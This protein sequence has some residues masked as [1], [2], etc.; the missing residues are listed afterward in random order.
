MSTQGCIKKKKK[1]YRDGILSMDWEFKILKIL[2]RTTKNK[3]GKKSK[4][5]KEEKKVSERKRE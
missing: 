1:L 5:R 3:S 4:E 2:T